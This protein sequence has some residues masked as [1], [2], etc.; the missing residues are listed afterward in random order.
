MPLAFAAPFD[1][2]THPSRPHL[3][4]PSRSKARSLLTHVLALDPASA[5]AGVALGTDTS[6]GGEG[7]GARAEGRA[8]VGRSR[9]RRRGKREAGWSSTTGTPRAAQVR[10]LASFPLRARWLGWLGCGAS[11]SV[12]LELGI[13]RRGSI[14]WCLVSLGVMV[15]VSYI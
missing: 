6:E 12:T 5:S 4:L 14:G 8:G 9:R 11:V 1:R 2:P 3:P 7:R 13:F 10:R 15:A